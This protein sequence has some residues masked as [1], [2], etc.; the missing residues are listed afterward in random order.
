[1]DTRKF[2]FDRYLL[3]SGR[4]VRS[5]HGDALVC[6]TRG[7]RNTFLKMGGVCELPAATNR[8]LGQV[9]DSLVPFH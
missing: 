2:C 3:R 7:L 5:I 1:V 6:V 9:G 8:A 4:D